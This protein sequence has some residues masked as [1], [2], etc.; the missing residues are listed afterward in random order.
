MTSKQLYISRPEYQEF[1]F[2][3]FRARIKQEE[4]TQKYFHHLEIKRTQKAA[5]VEQS[6]AK[7]RKA[8]APKAGEAIDSKRMRSD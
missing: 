2:A 1:S 3:I 5:K 7:A 6:R 8:K 4:S